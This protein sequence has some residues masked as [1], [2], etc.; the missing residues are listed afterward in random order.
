VS[1]I[2]DISLHGKLKEALAFH[3]DEFAKFHDGYFP[4]RESYPSWARQPFK[5]SVAT[6]DVNDEYLD[7]ISE[8]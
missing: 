1:G 3:L 2:G 4:T 7:E 6:A 8:L 5:F